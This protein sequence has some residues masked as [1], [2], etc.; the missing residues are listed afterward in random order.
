MRW[1]AEGV[2]SV[3]ME[4]L[5]GSPLPAW[6][7][8][9]HLDL[10][11]PGVITRQYS[12]CGSPADRRTWRIAVLLEPNSRGGSQAVHTALRPGDHVSVVGPRNNF[13]LVESPNYL[14]IAGGIGITP[15]IPMLEVADSAGSNWRL[16]YGGRTRTAMA[17]AS[18]LEAKYGDR[19]Q[20]VP[21]DV[22][23]LLDLESLLG[24][25]EEATRI[26][27]CGPEPLLSAVENRCN[28]TWPSG[29]LHVERFL[30]RP[31]QA[32][33]SAEEDSFEVVLQRTGR[34]VEVAPGQSVLE[35]LDTAGLNFPSSCREGICGTCEAKVLDGVPDHRDSLLSEEERAANDTMMIC[36]GRS[37]GPRLVLDL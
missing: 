8:G 1:E 32:V 18:D 34:T 19:V 27:C 2:L 35:A 25:P 30:A 22:Y 26:Y 17:F 3:E 4:F 13:S 21:Q 36:V 10:H 12:L 29:A 31:R 11:L 6:A 24:T 33:D 23:G 20:V 5:D 16:V 15:L 14:F 9:S 37:K 28:G 7:P